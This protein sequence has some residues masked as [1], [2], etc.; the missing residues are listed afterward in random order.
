MLSLKSMLKNKQ[1]KLNL[2][3]R[4][5]YPYSNVLMKNLLPGGLEPLIFDKRVNGS[6]ETSLN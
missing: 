1:S 4:N 5:C 3:A 2:N 6:I